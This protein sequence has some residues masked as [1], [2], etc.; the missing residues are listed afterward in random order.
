MLCPYILPSPSLST[1]FSRYCCGA[2]I[3][4]AST[5][6]DMV[7]G[8]FGRVFYFE[9]DLAETFEAHHLFEYSRLVSRRDF[10]TDLDLSD[11]V[12]L[13]PPMPSISQKAVPSRNF[14]FRNRLECFSMDSDLPPDVRNKAVN[15][16]IGMR[17]AFMLGCFHTMRYVLRVEVLLELDISYIGVGGDKSNVNIGYLQAL[18][19]EEYEIG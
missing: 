16:I 11:G 3:G 19:P 18:T 10:W 1:D 15:L 6:L 8:W 4:S 17:T 2:F 9:E 7:T 14:G 5:R 13:A 12:L